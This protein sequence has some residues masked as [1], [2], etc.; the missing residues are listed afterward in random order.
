MNP[1]AGLKIGEEKKISCPCW[2]L[3]RNYSASGLLLYELKCPVSQL[4]KT[5][6]SL[7]QPMSGH[8][9]FVVNRVALGQVSST[10]LASP[11]NHSTDCS[12]LITIH[13]SWLVQ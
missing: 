4:K 3:T 7:Q 13:H 6:H 8:V 10:T 11:A 12:A 9:G 1:R 5:Y 2:I